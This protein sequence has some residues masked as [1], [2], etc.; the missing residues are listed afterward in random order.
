MS[1]FLGSWDFYLSHWLVHIGVGCPESCSLGCYRPR[2]CKKMYY[3]SAAVLI[4]EIRELHSLALGWSSTSKS[5]RSML[6]TVSVFMLHL[7]WQLYLVYGRLPVLVSLFLRLLCMRNW[8]TG[9]EILFWRVQL[10][11]LVVLRMYSFKTRNIP[12]GWVSF[13]ITGLSFS[14]SMGRRLGRRADIP[15]RIQG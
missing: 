12:S 1:S 2:T 3:L 4:T 8:D 13:S 7:L 9:K 10:L 15:T 11:F 6:L 14:G 5:S